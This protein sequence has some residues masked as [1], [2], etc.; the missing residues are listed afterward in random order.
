MTRAVLFQCLLLFGIKASAQSA[1]DGYIADGLKNNLVIQQKTI[2]LEKSMYALKIANSLFMPSINAQANYTSG[3]GGRSID[4]PIGDLMNPVYSTLNQLTSSNSFPQISNQQ[5]TFFP[6]NFYDAKIHTTVPIVNTDLFY[7]RQI[8]EQQQ[9]I[10]NDELDI[11]KRELIRNIRVAYFN[12]LSAESAIH[13]YEQ[14][15]TLAQEG[16]RVNESLLANGKG[17]PAYLIRSDAEIEKL[18]AQI[19]NAQL[20]AQNAQLYFNFLLNRDGNMNIDTTYDERAGIAKAAAMAG[21]STVDISAREELRMMNHAI[22]IN[23]TMLRM[24]KNFWVP[25]LGAFLDLGSQASNW[26]FNSQ[27]RY[28]L[29]GLQLDF[30]LFNGFRNRYRIEQSRFDLRYNQAGLQLLTRQLELS[31]S[32]SRNAIQSAYAAYRSAE[33]QNQAAITYRQLIEKGYQ[34]GTGTFLET[35]EAR[36]Q[37]TQAQLALSIARYKVLT[38]LANYDRETGAGF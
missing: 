14:S 15:L 5:I 35:V 27:S 33:K 24:N 31:A 17:L 11:Y 23:Q 21:A 28:Y 18:N 30:P 34:E 32:I 6:Q 16:K 10:Q 38:E 8:T 3:E 36:S 25:R 1:L 13:I 7:N 9:A 37:Q 12:Y 29:V 4:L 20:Q 2:S 19:T 26:A 22:G